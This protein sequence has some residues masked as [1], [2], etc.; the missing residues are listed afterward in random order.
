MYLQAFIDAGYDLSYIAKSGLRDEDLD[1][2]GMFIYYKILL[3]IDILHNFKKRT[4]SSL[5][6]FF[7]KNLKYIV[8]LESR[9]LE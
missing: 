8:F 7:V 2:V 5:L 3:L 1:C 9:R 6:L 4:A